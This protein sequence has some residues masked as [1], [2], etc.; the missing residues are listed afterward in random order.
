MKI[1]KH[2]A[3]KRAERIAERARVNRDYVELYRSCFEGTPEEV[4]LKLDGWDYA[5]NV[6]RDH[7]R[8]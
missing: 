5:H 3:S 8:W 2:L 1:F 4:A 6:T 7:Y